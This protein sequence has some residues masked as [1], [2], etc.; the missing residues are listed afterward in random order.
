MTLRLDLLNH[1][2]DADIAEAVTRNNHRYKS[3][4]LFSQTGTGSL[5]SASTEERAKEEMQNSDLRER[6]EKR[7]ASGGEKYTEGN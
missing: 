3:E 7:A 2:T 6:L 4:P 5:L 1:L